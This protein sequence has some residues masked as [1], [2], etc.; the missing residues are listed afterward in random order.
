MAKALFIEENVAQKFAVPWTS[1]IVACS[2]LIVCILPFWDLLA[3]YTVS[4]C[5][6]I[7]MLT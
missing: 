3:G 1:Y 6:E 4:G 7:T 2:L 5:Y